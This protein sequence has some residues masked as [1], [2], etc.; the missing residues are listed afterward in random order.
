MALP[1]S[2]NQI[3]KLGE[4][5][6]ADALLE[7]D[8]AMLQAV[9]AHHHDI[10]A[11]VCQVL[12]NYHGGRLEDVSITGRAKT[13][14]TML[15]KLARNRT[16]LSS[17]E[18][19][20]GVRLVAHM[21]LTKQDGVAHEI[22]ELLDATNL[23]DRRT[24]P[25]SGYR[26]VHVIGR[27][28]GTPVEVQIRTVPQDAWANMFEKIADLVGREIRY[29]HHPAGLSPEK[30]EGMRVLVDGLVELSDLIYN[31]EQRADTDRPDMGLEDYQDALAALDSLPTRVTA[32][33]ERLG[34]DAVVERLT[35]P[36]G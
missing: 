34:V 4:R 22:S 11:S 35:S 10:Q 32:V 9:I 28:D 12:D 23:V 26:A 25:R 29:G 31:V 8:P 14:P 2:K 7:S 36:Q 30:Q 15:E 5:L 13:T 19:L 21:S 1:F 20:A 33:L 16:R 17:M 24:D 27:F 6:R 18:D 3:D